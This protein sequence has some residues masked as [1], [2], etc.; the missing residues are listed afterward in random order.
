MLKN[1]IDYHKLL[2]G[3]DEHY[4]RQLMTK[5]LLELSAEKNQ[6]EIAFIQ[7]QLQSSSEALEYYKHHVTYEIALDYVS[8]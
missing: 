3:M 2:A 4:R 5:R 6:R 7:E 8:K 1:D